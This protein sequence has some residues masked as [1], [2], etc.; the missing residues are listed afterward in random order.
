MTHRLALPCL[1]LS[2]CVT[3]GSAFATPSASKPVGRPPSGA[4][5]TSTAPPSTV[6]TATPAGA[7][8]PDAA[9][10]FERLKALAGD[11]E[12]ASGM[13][14]GKGPVEV[15]YRVTGG[16]SAVVETLFAGTPHEMMTVYHRDGADLVLTHY[17]AS[18]NQPRMRAKAPR[19]AVLSFEFEGGTNFN[20]ARDMHMHQAKLEFVSGDELKSQWVAWK[21]GKPD[22]HSPT[23][24]F[25]RKKG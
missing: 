12:D 16:G 8:V 9:D 7:G 20:P 10:P 2:L 21:G 18:G 11:W 17:C 14:G 25:I 6:P 13:P 4:T 3:A 19:G 5:G 23:F 22:G 24:R 1:A 15:T